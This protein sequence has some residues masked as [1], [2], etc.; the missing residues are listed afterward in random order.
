MERVKPVPVDQ[1]AG[2]EFFFLFPRPA[3]E[4]HQ[5]CVIIRWLSGLEIFTKLVLC[6]F[7]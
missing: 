3:T 4:F 5:K 6:H 7:V 2:M 1:F